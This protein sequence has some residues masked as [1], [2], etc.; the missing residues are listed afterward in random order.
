M[1]SEGRT[2]ENMH[3]RLQEEHDR[4]GA[5]AAQLQAKLDS[6]SQD[7]RA[8]AAGAIRGWP[9]RNDCR[10]S[11]MPAMGAR[12]GQAA[13]ICAPNGRNTRVAVCARALAADAGM[14]YQFKGSTLCVRPQRCVY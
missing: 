8:K 13:E 6:A 10:I 5:Q 9:H 11:R 3:R 2:L 14:T 1:A 7:A 12:T 4:V